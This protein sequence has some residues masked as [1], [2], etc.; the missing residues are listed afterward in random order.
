MKH[1]L[2]NRLLSLALAVGLVVGMLPGVTFASA[3]D[4]DTTA[5]QSQV[6]Q[7]AEPTEEPETVSEESS[8]A[9]ATPTPAPE[10]SQVEETPA[11]TEEP[12]DTEDTES[13][14]IPPV[15]V[16][17]A[18]PLTATSSALPTMNRKNLL[19][20]GKEKDVTP[21]NGLDLVKVVEGDRKN[22]YKV[23]LEVS[24]TGT[25]TGG[26]PIPADIVLVLDV[27]GSMKEEMVSYGYNAVRDPDWWETYY[28]KDGESYKTVSYCSSRWHRDRDCYH[29][30]VDSTHSQYWNGQIYDDATKYERVV[31]SRVS[32]MEALRTAVDA[33]LDSVQESAK[34]KDGVLG[35]M[36]DVHHRVSFVKFASD[37]N[38]DIGNDT[39]GNGY[40]DSQQVTGLLDMTNSS[41][42][43][44]IMNALN[45]IHPAGATSADYGMNHAADILGEARTAGGTDYNRGQVAILFTDGDPNHY[46]GFDSGVADDTISEASRIKKAG[47]TVYSIGI[48]SGADGT[49]P[50]NADGLRNLSDANRY[51]HL[52]S[53]NFPDATGWEHYSWGSDQWG[54]LNPNLEEG[55]SYYLSADNTDGLTDIFENISDEISSPSIS[56]D[57]T[58]KIRDVVTDYFDL[59]AEANVKVEK[60]DKRTAGW[61]QDED[62]TL[63]ENNIAVD[64]DTDT[65]EVTGI[66]LSQY[67]ILDEPREN[68]DD[69]NDTNYYGSKFVITFPITVKQDFFGGNGV[70]TNEVTD[71]GVFKGDGTT[72]ENFP[73]P[74]T[75][76]IALKYQFNVQDQTIYVSESANLSE[77]I[78]YVV[79]YVPGTIL[80]SADTEKNNDY[81]DLVFTI[82][83][84]AGNVV[85]TYTVAAKSSE[86]SWTW[87]DGYTGDYAKFKDCTDFTISCTVQPKLEGSIDPMDV[88]PS[89]NPATVHVLKPT[90]TW[91]DTTKDKDSAINA[92][93]L[94]GENFVKVE[95]ADEKS[96]HTNI[97]AAS[98][99]KPE[100]NY[101]F[102]LENDDSLPET[103]TAELHV[104]V[105]TVKANDQDIT[106]ETNFSWEENSNS[107]GCS[108]CQ[109]PNSDG[110]QFRIHMHLTDITLTLQKDLTAFANNGKPVFSFKITNLETFQVWYVHADLTDVTLREDADWSDTITLPAGKY[111]IVELSNQN[112]ALKEVLVDGKKKYPSETRA[113]T[114]PG[115]EE[116]LT[117]DTIVLFKNDPVNSNIPTDGSA[118]KNTVTSVSEGVI[119]WKQEPDEYGKD[120]NHNNINPNDEPA[121]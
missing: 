87:E 29:H 71:S 37:N 70:P 111:Q 40:N 2:Y 19:S 95:W 104:K 106:A 11:P 32:R 4:S 47:G 35:T 3:V 89:H 30:W 99:E 88:S 57:E 77:L 76:D 62:W 8:Q 52:V 110:Y 79:G 36:D 100:L 114:Y 15:N 21:D 61:V 120:P 94:N 108:S 44:T 84:A 113:V 121:E 74:G 23:K 34:G 6:E 41:S 105:N 49:V 92:D 112:Y 109:D 72:V 102:V 53:S 18:A 51:M 90:V 28:V 83:D 16:T 64:T 48:F 42:A 59:P 14:F 22:G 93:V 103:L 85:G 54:G 7:I 56:L 1:K 39:N 25:V 65:V 45:S 98:S 60:W 116:D 24:T 10:S 97:P 5:L 50:E 55:E 69:P 20:V 96:D 17:N 81:V 82:R 91:K 12:E 75:Q 68:P 33:F 26:D 46:N 58:T 86:G 101:T 118:T 107:S 27:S 80:P 78:E 67:F 13:T 38:E 115:I 66:N 119:T 31:V 117:E 73:D 9:E 63:A 43:T